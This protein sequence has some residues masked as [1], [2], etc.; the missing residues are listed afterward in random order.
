MNLFIAIY[1][2]RHGV[3][4]IP[5]FRKGAPSELNVINFINESS[6]FA[7]DFEE[8][9]RVDIVGP[10]DLPETMEDGSVVL[11]KLIK[12]E[13]MSLMWAAGEKVEE[14]TESGIRDMPLE[15]AANRL[16]KIL[17][18]ELNG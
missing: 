4:V 6:D 12:N 3:D 2:H 15:W 13:A 16:S 18:P 10:F 14:K 8:G 17:E 9:E 11:L 5:F 1:T 7:G